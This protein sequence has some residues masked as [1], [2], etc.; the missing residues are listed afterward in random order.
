MVTTRAFPAACY[1]RGGDGPSSSHDSY[2][3]LGHSPDFPSAAVRALEELA[4]SVQWSGGGSAERYSDCFALWPL[5]EPEQGLLLARLSDAGRDEWGRPHALRVEVVFVEACAASRAPEELAALLSP[6][7]WPS[8]NWPGPPEV[9]R[10]TPVDRPSRLAKVLT[11]IAPTVGRLPRTLVVAHAH[12]RAQGF[13]LQVDAEG[14]PLRPSSPQSLGVPQTRSRTSSAADRRSGK[15]LGWL[16]TALL[17]IA[18][19]CLGGWGH[20]HR[21]CQEL[22]EKCEGLERMHDQKSDE[23]QTRLRKEAEQQQAAQAAHKETLDQLQDARDELDR[24]RSQVRAYESVSAELDAAGPEGLRVAIRNQTLPPRDVPPT[25]RPHELPTELR[26]E[27]QR[28]KDQVQRLLDL[29]DGNRGHAGAEAEPPAFPR[30]DHK[31]AVGQ[32]DIREPAPAGM[33]GGIPKEP[34]R[35][36]DP[37]PSRP[38]GATISPRTQGPRTTSGR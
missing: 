16:L 25:D 1:G 35:I 37:S 21:R 26:D 23:L 27:L 38:S 8:A 4:G 20:T 22:Q 32:R 10:L 2:R 18:V 24:L 28:T 3:V 31:S 19:A 11:Q 29:L 6:D 5:D 17:V 9:L 33:P 14:Q 34:E 13:D 12:F 15:W 30:N 7:A 36:D